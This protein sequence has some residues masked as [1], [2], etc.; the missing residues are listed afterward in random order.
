MA[1]ILEG[2]IS[3]KQLPQRIVLINIR[4]LLVLDELQNEKPVSLNHLHRAIISFR[5][6]GLCLDCG[7]L[8]VAPSEPFYHVSRTAVG[9]VVHG[10]ILK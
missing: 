7:N 10:L 2:E 1:I 8:T 3:E 9:T 4:Q 6:A 5:A